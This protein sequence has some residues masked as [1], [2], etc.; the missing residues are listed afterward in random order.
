MNEVQQHLIRK[1]ETLL[2]EVHVQFTIF[3]YTLTSFRAEP[4][5]RNISLLISFFNVFTNGYYTKL[6][7]CHDLIGMNNSSSTHFNHNTSQIL[8]KVGIPVLKHD[9]Q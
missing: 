7:V 4:L 3:V 2:T 9:A 5:G 1:K 6:T 8:N